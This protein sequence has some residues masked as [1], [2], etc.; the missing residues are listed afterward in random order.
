MVDPWL[1]PDTLVSRQSKAY[2]SG[3]SEINI[4]ITIFDVLKENYCK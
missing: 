1:I 4:K 2:N 3:K